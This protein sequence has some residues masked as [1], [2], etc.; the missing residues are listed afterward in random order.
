MNDFSLLEQPVKLTFDGGKKQII[1]DYKLMRQVHI[2]EKGQN[3]WGT[4]A[5]TIDMGAKILFEKK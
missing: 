4:R 1:V 3:L 2:R 5:G